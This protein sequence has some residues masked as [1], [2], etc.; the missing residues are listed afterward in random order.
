M[1]DIENEMEL[2]RRREGRRPRVL[3]AGGNT[4]EST[5]RLKVL[6]SHY[7]DAGFDVDLTLGTAGLDVV[8][9]MAV[10]NDVHTICFDTRS[11]ADPHG[12]LGRLKTSL[13]TLDALDIRVID[14]GRDEPDAEFIFFT[15]DCIVDADWL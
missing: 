4:V 11:L 1:R 3:L 14:W 13:G 7:S 2:F 5:D 8:A 15:L 10:E 6:A 9:R 12:I